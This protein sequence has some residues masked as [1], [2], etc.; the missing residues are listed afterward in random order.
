MFWLASLRSPAIAVEIVFDVTG[1][2]R[3]M[4]VLT[5]AVAL[6]QDFLEVAF[7]MFFTAGLRTFH[8][9]DLTEKISD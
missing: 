7:Q 9:T 5:I 3:A 1:Q 6:P 4:S 8:F 2:S